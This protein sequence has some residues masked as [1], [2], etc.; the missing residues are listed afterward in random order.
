MVEKQNRKHEFFQPVSHSKIWQCSKTLKAA[1]MTHESKQWNLYWTDCKVSIANRSVVHLFH[2]VCF[3]MCHWGVHWSWD[4]NQAGWL[5]ILKS[6]I[7]SPKHDIVTWLPKVAFLELHPFHSPKP[8]FY[9]PCFLDFASDIA[10]WGQGGVVRKASI[11]M[12]QHGQG[13]GWQCMTMWFKKCPKLSNHS[14]M[15]NHASS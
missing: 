1:F 2:C 12:N 3:T 13:N 15:L 11:N 10:E 9:A 6:W 4:T 5:R 7:P 8:H 14:K